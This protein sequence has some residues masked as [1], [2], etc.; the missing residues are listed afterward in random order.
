MKHATTTQLKLVTI[1]AAVGLALGSATG[2]AQQSQRDEGPIAQHQQQ[3]QSQESRRQQSQ[4]R[5]DG[6]QDFDKLAQQ[7]ADLTTFVHAIETAGLEGSLTDGTDYTVFAPTNQAFESMS[8]KS[9]DELM[10]SENRDEL[11]S[12][13]RAHIV[14]DDVGPQQVKQLARAETIDGGT[15]DLDNE[16]GS[17]MVGGAKVVDA[18]GIALT[19][20]VRVYP[21]DGVLSANAATPGSQ[22]REAGQADRRQPDQARER[23]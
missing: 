15:V 18:Q 3:S 4:T 17:L 13:L 8:G 5:Q 6:K 22:P 7:H 11:V 10:K 21:I 19:E 2:F 1:G 9:T 14:A 23:G 12:L 16:N 20:S